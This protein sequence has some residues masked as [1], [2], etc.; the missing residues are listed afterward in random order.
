MSATTTS[1]PLMSC[2]G[3]GATVYPE[4]LDRHAAGYWAGQL[5]CSYCLA[6]KKSGGAQPPIPDE[7][8][9]FPLEEAESPPASAAAPAPAPEPAPASTPAVIPA[10]RRSSRPGVAGA[11]RLRIFHAKLSDGAVAHL[12]HQIN[13]WLDQT[14]DVEIKFATTTVGVWEGKHAEPNLIMTLFY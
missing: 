5:F 10:S 9:T 2:A 12:D 14:P 11:T 7:V 13:D 4:H 1:E 3:C 6:D 8:T